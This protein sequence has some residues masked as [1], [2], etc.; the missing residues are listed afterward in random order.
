MVLFY[1]KLK[2]ILDECLE[3][4]NKYELVPF[5]GEPTKIADVLMNTIRGT[6]VPIGAEECT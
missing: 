3:C 2:E 4:R 1:Q 5:S 6:A